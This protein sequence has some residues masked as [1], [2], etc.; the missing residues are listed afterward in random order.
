MLQ[1]LEALFE[2]LCQKFTLGLHQEINGLF[3]LALNLLHFFAHRCPLLLDPASAPLPHVG[4]RQKQHGHQLAR[5][6]EP[7]QHVAEGAFYISLL[8]R[9]RV[10]HAVF[11]LADIVGITLTVPAA[12]PAGLERLAAFTIDGPAQR[13]VFADVLANRCAWTAV[14]ALLDRLECFERYE[15]LMVAWAQCHIP[16]QVFDIS[17]VGYAG[18]NIGHTLGPNAAVL[19][20]GKMRLGGKEALDLGLRL[21]TSRGKAL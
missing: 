14:S 20:K 8:D 6:C 5:G 3:R 4:E 17:G 18:E 13:I 16:I 2:I 15:P 19:C 10:V 12:G 1:L 21:E 7:L 11:R 9:F